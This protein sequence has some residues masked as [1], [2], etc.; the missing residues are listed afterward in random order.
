MALSPRPVGARHGARV[1]KT[2]GEDAGYRCPPLHI[3]VCDCF[4][5]YA[6]GP[7]SLASPVPTVY[8]RVCGG[9]RRS[10]R[11]AP[12]SHGLSPRVR[13]NHPQCKLHR[14]RPGSIP[15]C[16]GEPPSPDT[17]QLHS[18]VYPR[19]CGGTS[20]DAP[21]CSAANGLS[22]RVRGNQSERHHLFACIR[23]IPAC[24]GEP[25]RCHIPR[26]MWWVYPRVCGGTGPE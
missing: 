19:V 21:D 11:K 5:F 8:P 6:D 2:A 22:P 24:A 17:H 4:A 26:Y 16:A 1:G 3:Y 15:A 12:F 18:E 23:S 20:R 10:S 13:G 9:T 25:G 7:R 14:S